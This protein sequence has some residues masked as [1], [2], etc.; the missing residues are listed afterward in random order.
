MDKEFKTTFIPKKN[1]IGAK[2]PESKTVK[3]RRSLFG[4]LAL[5][6]FVTAVVSTIGVYLY[7]ARLVSV[8]NSR[9]DSINRAEKAF[10]PSVILDLK[11][12]DIRLRA[13]TEL[14]N[15]HVA[16]SDFLD[17][18]GESTLPDISFREFSFSYAPD[19][20]AVSMTGEAKGYLQ[21]AQ[22]SDIFESNN[23]IQNHIF[24]DFALTDTGRITFSLQFT[25]NPELLQFGRTV[26][27]TESDTTVPEGVIIPP[28][29]NEI[30]DGVDINFDGLTQ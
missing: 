28:T 10:E 11:K 18:L 9:I 30:P 14:L 7:K 24:S 17:S 5:L 1:P 16:V 23:Y 22:Q 20:S 21:I 25:L 15:Q 3:A 13:G 6:L 2:A 4:I 8:I 29:N 26:K 12:L 27:N 19:G